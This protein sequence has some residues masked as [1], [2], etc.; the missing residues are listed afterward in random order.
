[1][2]S[3][4]FEH[5]KNDYFDS[6]AFHDIYKYSSL[7]SVVD[8]AKLFFWGGGANQWRNHQPSAE[9]ARFLR[10]SGGILPRENF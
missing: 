3:F 5:I 4:Q 10:G 9:G 7:S 1:M 6:V 2:A 8:P